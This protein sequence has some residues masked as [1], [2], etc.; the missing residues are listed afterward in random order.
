M[1]QWFNDAGV[2][3]QRTLTVLEAEPVDTSVSHRRAGV[4][5]A[6]AKGIAYWATTAVLIVECVVSG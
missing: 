4:L 3:P 2:E 5:S 6:Q 1:A